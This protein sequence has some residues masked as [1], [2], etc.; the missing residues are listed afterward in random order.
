MP[1]TP[2]ERERTVGRVVELLRGDDRVEGV[3]VVGSMAG[4]P[5]AWSDV[6]L[7]VVL[8]EG[9]SAAA[10]ATDWIARLRDE[11]PVL[12]HFE[13][14]FGETPVCGFLL[15]NLLEID[16][17]FT[18]TDQFAVW[19]PARSAFDR[20]GLVEAALDSTVSADPSRPDWAGEAGFGWHDVL[21]AD[22]ALRRGRL[23][24]A[25]WYMERVRN[26]T[27]SLASQRHGWYADFFDY[28]D[29]LAD[30]ERA[31]LE[32]TLVAGL[33]PEALRRANVAAAS[34]FLAE[35]RR[36]DSELADRL[37]PLLERVS[38]PL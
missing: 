16:L 20:S 30:D 36:G 38:A 13:T 18:P 17:A 6:D 8:T 29:D 11:L 3:V 23:W 19:G 31:P 21:H 22:T 4:A 9:A 28:V 35:L 24:Q 10:V 15:D 12:H 27:L 32:E 1:F 34:G 37:A 14:A 33:E 2:E 5:D 25:R 7:A 26:R